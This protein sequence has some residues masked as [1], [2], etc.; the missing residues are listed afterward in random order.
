MTRAEPLLQ[1]RD[2]ATTLR[3]PA[4]L[5]RAGG[6][7]PFTLRGVSFS[8]EPGDEVAVIGPN[9]AGKTT[10]LRLLAGVYRAQAGELRARGRVSA[11]IG[12]LAVARVVVIL[13]PGLYWERTRDRVTSSNPRRCAL[14]RATSSTRQP[15]C[16]DT[17]ISAIEAL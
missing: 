14:I 6:P 12:W 7:A 11:V 15:V 17:A 5:G 16:P 13:F 8:V 4:G 3:P 10:L 1:V 9:G 2:L